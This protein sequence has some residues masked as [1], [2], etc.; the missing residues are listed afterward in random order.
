M[1]K[2]SAYKEVYKS[3]IKQ[4]LFQDDKM[5]TGTGIGAIATGALLPATAVPIM[6]SMK[7]TKSDARLAQSVVAKAE[8]LLGNGNV[9]LKDGIADMGGGG[10]FTGDPGVFGKAQLDTF[11]ME[12]KSIY[13]NK[14]M[15]T[16]PYVLAHELGHAT[17]I[18]GTG[19]GFKNKL[20][21]GL[22]KSQPI[23]KMGLRLGPLGSIIAAAMA[24]DNDTKSTIL[25]TGSGVT[26][27]AGLP[28]L[29]EEALASGRALKTLKGINPNYS[30]ARA[31]KS[32]GPAFLSYLGTV[33]GSASIPYIVNKTGWLED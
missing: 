11:G 4:A 14:K 8:E 13:A 25:N 19:D 27:A 15:S 9:H 17:N 26:A 28:L 5:D 29:L 2:Y 16:N 3:L 1:D 18:L 12:P 10:L 6:K 7:T 20:F 31:A 33:L 22:Q 23:G 32:L 24:E 30:R 21:R